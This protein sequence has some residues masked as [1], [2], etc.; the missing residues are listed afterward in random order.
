MFYQKDK[1]LVQKIIDQ[2][3]SNN[4]KIVLAEY[5]TD[6][7]CNNYLKGL[8]HFNSVSTSLYNLKSEKELASFLGCNTLEKKFLV[9]EA[10]ALTLSNNLL[11]KAPTADLALGIV[12]DKDNNY[13]SF[14]IT[15]NSKVT[16]LLH[17]YTNSFTVKPAFFD[18]TISK[19]TGDD[20][21]LESNLLDQILEKGFQIIS[22]LL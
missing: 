1:K 21:N 8:N 5:G 17:N 13:A 18:E 4:I 12:F 9:N 16:K 20:T 6:G 3:K 10:T 11:K 7:S 22:D 19:I 2:L 15:T 14:G